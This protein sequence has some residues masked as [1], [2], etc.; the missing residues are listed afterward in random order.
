MHIYL[1]D[2]TKGGSDWV[3]LL[4]DCVLKV[5]F[6]CSNNNMDVLILSY[7]FPFDLRFT[8]NETS[9]LGLL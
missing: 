4:V 3:Y 1:P 5:H 8:S 9:I 6:T 2:F 7:P